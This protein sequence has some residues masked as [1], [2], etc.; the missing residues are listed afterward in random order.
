MAADE[1]SLRNLASARPN[2]RNGLLDGTLADVEAMRLL[3]RGSSVIDWHRLAFTDAAEVDRFLRLNEFDPA[4]GG[5]VDRLEE[6]R[7]DAVEY[8]TRNFSYRIPQ[9]VSHGMPAR[10]LFLLASSRGKKQT[11]ACI[12]L[13]V[14]HV[15]HHL[16]GRELLF[17]LPVSADEV[18]GFVEA[19]V[20][21]VVEEIRA[22]GYPIVEFAWS[23]KERDSVVTKLLAKKATIAADVFD[24]LR[25]RLITR[26]LADLTPVMHELLHK[27]IPFNY[28]IPGQTVNGILPFRRLLDVAPAYAR[29]ADQ[30]QLDLDTEESEQTGSNEFSGPTYR[31]INFVADLPVRIDQFLTRVPGAENELGNVIF[32]LTEFQVMDAETARQNEAG[33]NS[34]QHYK[35]RQHERV[36]FRLTQGEKGLRDAAADSRQPTADSPES[37]EESDD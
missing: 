32:V 33:E 5:D 29:Y 24:K 37:D 18:F 23:R 2:G 13:K 27:L 12:V 3:L 15:M 1:K 17:K 20:V 22:A 14:M 25:F 11:Y 31:V 6:L 4:D 34:H 28:V 19:K 10:D 35:A 9:D 7:A 8:L 30:L 16:A 21:K 36:K 26:D